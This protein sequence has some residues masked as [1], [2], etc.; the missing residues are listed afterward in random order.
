MQK[1]VSRVP[2]DLCRMTDEDLVNLEQF[3]A[4]Q[5]STPDPSESS[6]NSGYEVM[7]AAERTTEMTERALSVSGQPHVQMTEDID[8]HIRQRG[9]V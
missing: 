9:K 8:E 5:R 3:R 7:T 2:F 4:K 1:G 6:S